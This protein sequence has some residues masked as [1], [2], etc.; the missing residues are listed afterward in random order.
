MD[1]LFSSQ[2]NFILKRGTGI[3]ACLFDSDTKQIISNLIPL[4]LFQDSGFFYFDYLTNKNRTKVN[5]LS[6]VVILRPTNLKLL[7]EELVSP[8]Y[9]SYIIL[10]TSQV[11]P[12]A[13]EIMANSDIHSVVSEIHEINLDLCKQAPNLYTTSI[14][15]YKGCVDSILSTLLSLEISP[16]IL[17]FD[18]NIDNTKS[19]EKTDIKGI[20]YLGKDL[21]SKI[22][23][24]NFKQ[25]GTLVLLKRS[26]DLITPLLYDW[27]YHAM[28]N[29]HFKIENSL[30][31][32]NGKNVLL[33]NSFFASNMFKQIS[34][35]GDNIKTLLKEVE[36]NKLEITDFG[37]I[38]ESINQK[39]VAETHLSIYNKIINEAMPLQHSSEV[40]N[41]VLQNKDYDIAGAIEGME[42]KAA[43]K[44]LLLYFLKYVKN[45]DECSKQYPKYR[46]DIMKFYDEYK[47]RNYC[48]KHGFN[49]EIDI[50]LGYTTPLKRII[51]HIAL[52]KL[53][54]NSF[55]R[56]SFSSSNS[57]I[58]I[59]IEGGVT[60]KEYREALQV[61]NEY[62]VEVILISDKILTINGFLDAGIQQT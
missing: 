56:L 14:Q 25:T 20:K 34:E 57:P 1:S 11:D 38:Q 53:K 40:E 31:A 59:Y 43:L 19:S 6:C 37:E 5:G 9:T 28:I 52:D 33:S 62:K 54:E 15:T 24:F 29:E 10:F 12:F 47:P 27:H 13:L 32:V 23:L 17:T 36:K 22:G 39:A 50:K 55:T 44:L 46:G 61:A 49:T 21:S 7:L 48:Y 45:W 8:F 51:K 3:K 16:A 60:L 30:V 58:I 35:V 18:D 26:F 42:Y 2:I 41:E 4:S